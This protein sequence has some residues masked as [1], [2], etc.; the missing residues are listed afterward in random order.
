M[1]TITRPGALQACSTLGCPSVTTKV[2]GVRP[3]C[4]ECAERDAATQAAVAACNRK[5]PRSASSLSAVELWLVTLVACLILG[6]FYN[7]FADFKNEQK[8]EQKTA[9]QRSSATDGAPSA[10]DYSA[11]TTGGSTR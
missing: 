11:S 8:N 1:R 9:Q 3:L 7:H 5:H 4:L 10:Q 6:Y 2:V